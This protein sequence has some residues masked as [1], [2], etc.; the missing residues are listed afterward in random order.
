MRFLKH[1]FL[2]VYTT[3]A[4]IGIHKVWEIFA[5]T[6]RPPQDTLEFLALFLFIVLALGNVWLCTEFSLIII[7]RCRSNPPPY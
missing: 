4:L 2:A 7:R 5:G 1:F 6:I 3:I